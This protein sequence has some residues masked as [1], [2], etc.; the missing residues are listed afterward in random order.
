MSGWPTIKLHTAFYLSLLLLLLLLFPHSTYS[1]ARSFICFIANAGRQIYLP[2]ALSQQQFS[3]HP[4]VMHA[5][6]SQR[7]AQREAA[8]HNSQNKQARMHA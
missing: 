1:A 4:I 3:T 7:A 8:A 6:I 5:Q 2:T